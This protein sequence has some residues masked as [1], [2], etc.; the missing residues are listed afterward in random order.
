[1]ISYSYHIKTDQIRRIGIMILLF[2]L[3]GISSFGQK[4]VQSSDTDSIRISGDPSAIQTVN[5][6]EMDHSP[7]KAMIYG[8]VLPGLGQA[9]NKK[10]FDPLY[11]SPGMPVANYGLKCKLTF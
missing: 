4:G 6:E 3:F 8:L 9:Y 7:R 2:G 5:P 10:Y 11:L 1:M